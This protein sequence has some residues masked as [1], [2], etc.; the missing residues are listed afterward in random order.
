M[1]LQA[2]L[3]VSVLALAAA[4]QASGEPGRQERR[5]EL[6]LDL[7]F[8]FELDL[9]E[10]ELPDGETERELRQIGPRI[11]ESLKGLEEQLHR[12]LGPLASLSARE[13]GGRDQGDRDDDAD[14]RESLQQER[15]E[16]EKAR[17][18]LQRL[19][20]EG[21]SR[22]EQR[23]HEDSE[24]AGSEG[25]G[26]SARIAVQGPVTFMARSHAASIEIVAGKAGEVQLSLTDARKTGLTLS[27]HGD[28]VEALFDGRPSLRRGKL[29]VELPPGSHVD[30]Q[31]MA[32]DLAVK[33]VGGDARVR[34][35][36]GDVSVAGCASADLQSVSGDVRVEAASGAV[37]VQTVSG[38][39][40]VT[41]SGG[42]PQVNFGSTSGS[43]DWAGVC[44]K[45][46]RLSTE[47]IS[48]DVRLKVARGSSFAVSFASHSGKLERGGLELL[49]KREPRRRK[50]AG[51]L[52]E[53]VLGSGEGVIE[54]DA[55]S[56]DLRFEQK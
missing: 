5:G 8:D 39:S 31:S 35:L 27:S 16:L 53:A 46:C 1:K 56:G 2:A 11:A 42:A 22:R 12:D 32:G 10:L 40:T 55:F 45:G 15:R 24:P 4:R 20:E 6:D 44:G 7:D 37:R 25:A 28:R 19:R 36:S 54:S 48:G 21:R 47:T 13:R 49:V 41:S 3:I 9:G 33:G 18:E 50:W 29:R 14:D 26:S 17:R 23:S 52:T 51:G 34:T 30:L 43:L 38:N